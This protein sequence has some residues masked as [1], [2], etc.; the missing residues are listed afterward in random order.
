MTR[1]LESRIR[2]YRDHLFYLCSK[3]KGIDELRG[4][5]DMQK[6]GLI[7]TQLV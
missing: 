3:N 5:L 1:G 6:A 2:K 7:M 4:H